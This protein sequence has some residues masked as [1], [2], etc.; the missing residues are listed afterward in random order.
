M[1]GRLEPSP[2][3]MSALPMLGLCSERLFRSEVTWWD[4]PL[5][6]S[7]DGVVEELVVARGLVVAMVSRLEMWLMWEMCGLGPGEMKGTFWLCAPKVCR[8]SSDQDMV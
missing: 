5:S 4:A 3:I 7:H 8:F 1:I 6:R 2:I